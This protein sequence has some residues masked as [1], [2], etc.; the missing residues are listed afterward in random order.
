MYI[1]YMRTCEHGVCMCA[2]C[3]LTSRVAGRR[4]LSNFQRYY[5]FFFPAAEAQVE[6]M[7]LPD[8]G[9][10]TEKRRSGNYSM[11]VGNCFAE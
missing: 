8:F 5:I 9:R 11:Y 10:V 1:L 7:K 3:D 6:I 4:Q 2:T